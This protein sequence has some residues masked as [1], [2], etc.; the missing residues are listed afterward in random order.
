MNL[1]M[2]MKKKKNSKIGVYDYF[3]PESFILTTLKVYLKPDTKFKQRFVLAKIL[4]S[5]PEHRYFNDA[6]FYAKIINL[7]LFN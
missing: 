1:P 3:Y 4:R 5:Q 2:L 7:F 6:T